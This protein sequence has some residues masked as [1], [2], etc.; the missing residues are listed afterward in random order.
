MLIDSTPRSTARFPSRLLSTLVTV[1]VL[2]CSDGALVIRPANGTG[3]S[4][5]ADPGDGGEDSGGGGTG[6]NGSNGGSASAGSNA[7]PDPPG[8]GSGGAPAPLGDCQP[9]GV[10]GPFWLEEGGSIEIGLECATGAPLPAAALTLPNLPPNAAFD[11]IAHS[12]TFSPGLDQAGVYALDLRVGTTDS[13][14][15]EVQVADGFDLPGNLS[16][17]P[18]TYSEEFGLPVLHL[19]TDPGINDQDYLPASITYRGHAFQG[20]LAK[21]RGQSSRGYPKRNLTL[22]F[23]KEDRFGDP[24]ALPGFEG[25]RKI[26]VTTTFDDNTNL[27]ARLAFEL[28]NRIG[29]GNVQVKAYNAVVYLNGQFWGI[30]TITDHIDRYLLE[31]FGL[32]EDGNLYQAKTHDANFRL[33]QDT[34]PAVAKLSLSEGYTKEEGTPI[35]GEPG[36]N[37]DLEDLVGWVAT[38]PS[39]SFLSEMGSRIVRREYEDWWLLVSV[40]IAG[41]SAGKNSFHYRDP[42]LGAPDARFH[43]VPWDFNDSFG[44]TFYNDHADREA[45]RDPEELSSY[46]RLFERL[47]AEPSTRE[48][49]LERLR[50]TLENEWEVASV[51][52]VFDEWA[53]ENEPV[54]L[55]D[56]RKWGVEY[57]GYFAEARSTGLTTHAEELEYVRGWIRDRWAFVRD[58]YR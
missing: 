12:I 29:V 36:A 13:G 35:E 57:A 34:D 4:E 37:A 5:P 39:E 31:D 25:K 48:P 6:S 50:A 28:W 51:L 44:Q 54:A 22:K 3:G 53:A 2:A 16:V 43:V 1:S 11:P 15:I 45:T 32:H 21:Y 42:R 41:D 10:G 52:Q 20:A 30:Y 40:I 46:N 27:R 8:G 56:E 26:A 38:S 24:S 14:R 18:A 7:S 55:R 47:L 23:T 19:T 58:Y 17:D 9:R 33:T 49:L